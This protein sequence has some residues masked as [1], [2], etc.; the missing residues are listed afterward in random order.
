MRFRDRHDAGSRLADRLAHLTAERPVVFG[1]PRGGVPVA[2]E[3]ARALGA[4]LDVLVVRK[5]GCPGQPELGLGAIGEGGIRLLNQPLIGST[6]VSEHELDAVAA[7]EGDE[8][9]RRVRRYRGSRA[10]A[11]IAD[12]TVIVVDDG[13][14]TGFTARAALEVLRHRGA[15]RIVLAV[16][17]APA[18]TIDE[19][20]SVVDEAVCLHAPKSFWAIGQ[21]YD[22][23]DQ[24]GDDEVAGLLAATDTTAPG[25]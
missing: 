10:A 25:A 17:V 18:H 7:R 22:D 4:P 5:L 1:L 19:L 9:E 24:V 20:R 11:P 23:F 3:V 16:P 12:R 8:L 13:L 14:A 15:R 21:Y 6:G 2:H